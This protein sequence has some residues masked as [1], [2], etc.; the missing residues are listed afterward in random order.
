MCLRVNTMFYFVRFVVNSNQIASC[1]S[2]AKIIQ[3][4][5]T[6]EFRRTHVHICLSG[7]DISTHYQTVLL[8][9][10]PC[11]CVLSVTFFIRILFFLSFLRFV[12]FV[13]AYFISNKNIAECLSACACL[14]RLTHITHT[15]NTFHAIWATI[16]IYFP[17]IFILYFYVEYCKQY[18][19]AKAKM[20]IETRFYNLTLWQQKCKLKFMGFAMMSFNWQKKIL[21]LLNYYISGWIE[22]TVSYW[23]YYSTDG[24]WIQTCDVCV[25][26]HIEVV[27]IAYVTLSFDFYALCSSAFHCFLCKYFLCTIAFFFS[28]DVFV[29]VWLLLITHTNFENQSIVLSSNESHVTSKVW[30]QRTTNNMYTN[31]FAY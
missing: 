26:C 19:F 25:V 27:Y 20:K 16:A 2:Y 10:F 24:E 11:M 15:R 7:P 3:F 28:A 6:R 14:L 4:T 29:L 8:Q 12:Y 9:C 31:I 13:F 1:Y 5:N 17:L 21:K 22:Y 30:Y 18:N 23:S